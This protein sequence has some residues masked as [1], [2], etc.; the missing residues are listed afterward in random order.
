MIK[1][2]NND[3]QHANKR[4]SGKIK[5]E[6]EK[7]IIKVGYFNKNDKGSATLD[8]KDQDSMKLLFRINLTG[9]LSVQRINN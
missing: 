1:P 6:A 8:G 4:V 7:H 9:S 3:G 5:L 2:V